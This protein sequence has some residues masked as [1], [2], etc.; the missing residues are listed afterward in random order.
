MK[1]EKGSKKKIDLRRGDEIPDVIGGHVLLCFQKVEIYVRMEG[2]AS[3][4]QQLFS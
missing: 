4:L 3:V 1:T 2:W